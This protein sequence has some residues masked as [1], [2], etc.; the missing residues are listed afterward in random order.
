MLLELLT[1]CVTCA[2]W[3]ILATSYTPFLHIVWFN[4]DF[5]NQTSYQIM[6]LPLY[7]ILHFVFLIPILNW[8][9]LRIKNLQKNTWIKLAT[10][11]THFKS[12]LWFSVGW[13]L[14]TLI[15]VEVMRPHETCFEL[16]IINS[17]LLDM[18]TKHTWNNS[19]TITFST[20]WFVEVDCGVSL[21]KFEKLATCRP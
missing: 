18:C 15:H 3:A 9:K 13:E 21:R 8:W 14:Y 11:A 6:I 7:T 17:L 10:L 20:T 19:I 1:T 5:I 2:T 12:N 16:W 4:C